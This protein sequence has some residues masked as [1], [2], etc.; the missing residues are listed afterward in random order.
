M[1]V[2]KISQNKDYR[3][4]KVYVMEESRGKK[5][6]FCKRFS[7]VLGLNYKHYMSCRPNGKT[8][9]ETGKSTTSREEEVDNDLLFNYRKVD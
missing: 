9:L 6:T 3:L 4:V 1:V 5:Q 7:K 8:G 2:Q